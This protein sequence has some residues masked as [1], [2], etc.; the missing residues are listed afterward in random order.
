MNNTDIRKATQDDREKWNEFIQAHNGSFM[1]AWEWGDLKGSDT[2]VIR[3]IAHE[4]GSGVQHEQ[5]LAVAQLY[6][7]PLRFK[8]S[9]Y[10][11]PRGPIGIN[12]SEELSLLKQMP[13]LINN[14][15]VAFLR[16]D[17]PFVDDGDR[18]KALVAMGYRDLRDQVEPKH[19]IVI[20][21]AGVSEDL[22]HSMK[23][24]ARREIKKAGKGG[25]RYVVCA[26]DDPNFEQLFETFWKCMQATAG[27][28]SITIYS[29]AYY[30]ALLEALG[31]HATL[32]FVFSEQGNAPLVANVVVLF[33]GTATYLFGASNE[34]AG[35][36]GASYYAQY[37]TMLWAR[38][39][40]ATCYDLWGVSHRGWPPR[41]RGITFF[42]E[43]FGGEHVSYMG[44]Y[45]YVYQP[46]WYILYRLF[47][48]F[49]H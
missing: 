32:H 5:W 42:K 8:R 20:D 26:H 41:W 16:I 28:K 2:H 45:D 48:R 36:S 43:S 37:H 17:P 18:R 19:T 10:Y 49:S 35:K 15:Y 14:H 38:G 22:L 40:G 34:D 25:L 9:Y 44:A 33:G 1:Q 21:L 7:R 12:R 27:R 30:S 4:T 39:Q 24:R 29:K 6:R 13:S 31:T 47:R 46:I 11:M 23:Y 3:L